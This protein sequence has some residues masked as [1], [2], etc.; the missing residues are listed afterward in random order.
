MLIKIATL[1]YNFALGFSCWHVIAVN[2]LLLP[3][4]LRPHLF[5]RVVLMLGGMF[6]TL[7]G[8][9]ATIKTLDELG[10]FK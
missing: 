1:G 3:K 6:F 7:L 4:Q 5:I 2:S 10:W 9:A 8:V